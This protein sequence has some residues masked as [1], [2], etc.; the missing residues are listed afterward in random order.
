MEELQKQIIAIQLIQE[1]IV[2]KC[3]EAGIFS[4][5]EFET[6]LKKRVDKFNKDLQKLKKE[7]EQTQ[8]KP[9]IFMGGV[10]GEA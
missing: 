5:K 10:V 2:D 6:Q 4:R 9:A 8:N 3:D 7:E 1:L